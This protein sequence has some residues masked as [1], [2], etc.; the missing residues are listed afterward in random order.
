[1]KQRLRDNPPSFKRSAIPACALLSL[2]FQWGPEY[3][4]PM[5]EPELFQGGFL[6]FW[7]FFSET[8][9]FVKKFLHRSRGLKEHEHLSF[10]FTRHRKRVRNFPRCEGRVARPERERLLA[11]AGLLWLIVSG[12]ASEEAASQSLQSFGLASCRLTFFE[13]EPKVHK[14]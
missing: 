9:H 1:M 14:D 5:V 10:A 4:H 13:Q 7:D 8:T 12:P 11:D 2:K 6:I 3:L